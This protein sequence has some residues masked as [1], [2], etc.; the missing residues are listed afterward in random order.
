MNEK[1]FKPDNDYSSNIEQASEYNP[2]NDLGCLGIIIFIV[3]L[4]ILV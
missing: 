2:I 3:V 1:L 4:I